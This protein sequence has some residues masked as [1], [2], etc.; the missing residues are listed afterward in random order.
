MS[1]DI[2][3]R[4]MAAAAALFV[5]AGLGL[6]PLV[7]GTDPSPATL[8][9]GEITPGAGEKTTVTLKD[10]MILRPGHAS[11]HRL[12]EGAGRDQAAWLDGRTFVR[13]QAGASGT[14]AMRTPYGEPAVLGARFEVRSEEEELR[15]LVTNVPDE[16]LTRVVQRVCVT[17][18]NDQLRTG[19]LSLQGFD[20]AD[21]SEHAET[22]EKMI[23]KLRLNMMPPPA[24]P[25]PGGDTLAT[26]VER[27]EQ[28]IDEAVAAD[29]NP[30]HRFPQLLNRAEYERTIETIFGIRIDASAYLPPETVSDNFD[31]IADVQNVSVS[32]LSGYVNA[33][34]AVVRAAIGNPDAMPRQQDYWAA[35]T[36]GQNEWVE[37][38]PMGSRGG[39]V[40]IHNF[41]ADGEYV[42]EFRFHHGVMGEFVGRPARD[43]WL[44]LSIDG[45]R[46][47]FMEVDR[48]GMDEARGL[49]MRTEPITVRA[50]SRKVAA[51]FVPTH[52]G[53][54]ND[55]MSPIELSMSPTVGHQISGFTVLPHLRILSIRGPFNVTG[56]SE[57]D[58][59]R[60]IFTCRP[61]S[62]EEDRPCAQEIIQRIADEAF[63]EPADAEAVEHLMKIGRA[64]V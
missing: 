56:V 2:L 23:V 5:P 37:E 34:D 45:E 31:N 52:D 62:P 14:F 64:H 8:V 30:G 29:P 54:F 60:R 6:G 48:L 50:G 16:A 27:L 17:C 63:R 47:A 58:S 1:K 61:T 51:V 15:G 28:R 21:A 41:P 18:H 20:V 59:R 49:T 22:A 9:G 38:A 57:T 53:P 44:E 19:N 12:A 35:K 36:R 55:L 13:A 40:A 4:V 26:L 7:D 42:F 39:I 33:A 24:I 25:R 11:L 10:G 46:V 32:V 43:E 3:I